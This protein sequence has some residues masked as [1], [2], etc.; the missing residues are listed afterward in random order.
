MIRQNYPEANETPQANEDALRE[1]AYA[2]GAVLGAS[3]LGA[4]LAYVV[5]GFR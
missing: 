1:L 4:L 3:C 2:A 5:W